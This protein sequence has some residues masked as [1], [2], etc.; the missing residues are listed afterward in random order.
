VVDHH[1]PLPLVQ[2]I[3]VLG[4]DVEVNDLPT[5]M[6]KYD[7]D[8]QDTKS[9]GRNGKEVAGGDIRNMICEKRPP[10]LGRWL[11]VPDHVLGHGLFGHI[12]T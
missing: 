2:R 6:T 8:V 5:V 7:E 3:A 4:R 12:V 11:P 1:A 9:R 10:S